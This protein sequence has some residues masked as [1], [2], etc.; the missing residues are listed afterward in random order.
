MVDESKGCVVPNL[1]NKTADLLEVLV[2]TFN[3]LNLAEVKDPFFHLSSSRFFLVDDIL[4]RFAGLFTFLIEAFDS[5]LLL[6]LL[7]D[8]IEGVFL[9][10]K[11]N[12]STQKLLLCHITVRELV[13][14][15]SSFLKFVFVLP[16]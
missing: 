14:Q 5:L 2:G 12:V 16:L 3:C 9:I 6:L 15:D 11:E 8:V 7:L 4:C 1:V 10:T 13:L